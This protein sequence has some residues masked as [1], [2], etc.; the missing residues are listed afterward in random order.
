MTEPSVAPPAHTPTPTEVLAER[1]EA[2]LERLR[3]AR[4]EL[5]GRIDRAAGILVMQLSSP[6]ST[7]PMRVRAGSGGT[8]VLVS[9]SSQGGVVYCVDPDA[10]TCILRPEEY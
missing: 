10:W 2:E 5:E 8:R 6:P 9:S 1:I 7:Q 3:A 4:P